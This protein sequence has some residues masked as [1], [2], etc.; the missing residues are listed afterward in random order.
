MATIL[1]GHVDVDDDRVARISGSRMKVIDL[2]MT[3]LAN[4]LTPEQLQVEFSFLSL[5]EIH[6]AF[7]FYYDHQA[8]CDA[9]IEASVKFAAQMRAAAGPSPVAS[10][11]R[12]AGKLP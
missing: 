8:E 4:D 7:T 3:K 6:A 11:L 12:S 5:A 10:R 1:S 2:V 9:Q